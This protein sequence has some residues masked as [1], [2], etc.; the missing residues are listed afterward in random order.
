MTL[1]VQHDVI[2]KQFVEV[3]RGPH[4]LLSA[5][6]ELTL[7]GSETAQDALDDDLLDP[8][9]DLEQIQALVVLDLV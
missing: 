9:P 4:L 5:W 8:L 7:D 6:K 3:V 2:S 1:I